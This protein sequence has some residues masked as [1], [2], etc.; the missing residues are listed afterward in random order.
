[1]PISVPCRYIHTPTALLNL[2]DYQSVLSLSQ[3]VLNRI[4]PASF[5]RD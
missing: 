3:A 5:Q 4:R 2:D 1:M